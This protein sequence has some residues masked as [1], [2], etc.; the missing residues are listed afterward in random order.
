M[1]KNSIPNIFTFGNLIFGLLSLQ[2]TYKA[3]YKMAAI[4]IL[5]ASF[6]DR[7]DGRIARFF[8]ISNDIGKELDSLCDLVSF[9]VSPAMLVYT[10]YKLTSYGFLGYIILSIFPM[11]GAY[12]LA[13]YNTSSFKGTYSGVPITIAGTFLAFYCLITIN[14]QSSPILIM[15]FI[16]ILSYLM[17]SKIQ[18]TKI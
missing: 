6:M 4:Y 12:R 11:A 10:L 2:M 7:Y 9:G 14:N 8:N 13:R 3:N 17:V 5:I 15:V 1:L 16:V 18:I